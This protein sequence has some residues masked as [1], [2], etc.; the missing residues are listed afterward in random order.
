MRL[1][2]KT[3]KLLLLLGL[4]VLSCQRI[5]TPT[6]L[7]PTPETPTH[8]LNLP[9][10]ARIPCPEDEH[11]RNS[12]I[13]LW[14]HT[15]HPPK[16]SGSNSSK[17]NEVG[18]IHFCTNVTILAYEWSGFEREFWLMVEDQSGQRGW[19]SSEFIEFLP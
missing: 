15:A 13:T 9:T 14:Q 3:T 12:S 11:L 5:A 4:T 6:P 2:M 17:G 8:L 7:P 18:Q 19:L 10:T 1:L 16:E